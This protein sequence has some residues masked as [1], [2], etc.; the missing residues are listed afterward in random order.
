[1]RRCGAVVLLGA[2]LVTSACG[3]GGSDRPSVDEV[4]K[5]LRRAGDDS[6][7]GPQA[8]SISKKSADCIA[9]ALVDSKVSDTTLRKIVAAD[10]N[11]RPTSA[12]EA[13]LSK[14]GPA[15]V[16]CVSKK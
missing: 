13:A 6:L 14:L 9:K 4:S 12:D 3:G 11:F 15:L 5:A 16:R 7:L 10:K 8:K 1:M 2:L